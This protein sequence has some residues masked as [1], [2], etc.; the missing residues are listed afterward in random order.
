MEIELPLSTSH[1]ELNADPLLGA[2][3]YR[4]QTALQA[5]SCRG[6]RNDACPSG[7]RNVGSKQS[8]NCQACPKP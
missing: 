5:G 4:V 2:A 8:P 6:E 7:E 3:G 1:P